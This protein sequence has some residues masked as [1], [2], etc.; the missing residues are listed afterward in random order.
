MFAG[1][2]VDQAGMGAME[3]IEE[4]EALREWE[5]TC[6][7]LPCS[8]CLVWGRVHAKV[9]GQRVGLHPRVRQS[10]TPCWCAGGKSSCGPVNRHDLK[11]PR[12]QSALELEAAAAP[13]RHATEP[14]P[15]EARTRTTAL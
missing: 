9:D 13:C 8:W 1:V 14:H 11:A 15:K 3:V 6:L 10:G 4:M 12:G 2:P 5:G 7:A